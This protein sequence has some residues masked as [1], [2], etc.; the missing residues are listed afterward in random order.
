MKWLDLQLR[1]MIL[2]IVGDAFYNDTITQKLLSTGYHVILFFNLLA[3]VV[4][5][6]VR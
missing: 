3:L 5:W 4:A 1:K 2:S 6:L